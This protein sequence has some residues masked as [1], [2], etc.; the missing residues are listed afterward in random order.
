M[1]DPA[2][3]YELKLNNTTPIRSKPLK[4][5]PEEEAWLDLHLD[6]LEGKGVIAK[7]G[8]EEQPT[9]VTSLLLVPGIQSSQA[10]RVC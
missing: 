6:E 4:M 5:R 8:P 3:H 2:F 9:C 1:S 10:C 7:L